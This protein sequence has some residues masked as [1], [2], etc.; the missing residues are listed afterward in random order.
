MNPFLLSREERLTDWKALRTQ[1]RSL[2]LEEAAQTVAR[3]WARAPLMK[4][5]YDAYRLET[6]PGPWEMVMAGD[7]CRDSVAVGME[8]TLRL[9]G[10]SQDRLT[11]VMIKDYDVSDQMLCLK[12]DNEKLLNYSV[13]EVV[14]YPTTKH[15][16]I[17]QYRFNGRGYS[18]YR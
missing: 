11:L 4:C 3:Y 17:F 12:I 16:I 1:L 14:D 9:A 15:D 10:F 8:F 2:D 7:W 13:A 6:W 5:A 18:T